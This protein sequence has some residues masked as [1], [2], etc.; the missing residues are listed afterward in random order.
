MEY[1]RIE[2]GFCIRTQ[3]ET[4]P[5][6]MVKL[7][8]QDLTGAI[9][10]QDAG[11]VDDLAAPMHWVKILTDFDETQKNGY[12]LK[13]LA[14][15]IDENHKVDGD[16]GFQIRS[17]R[18]NGVILEHFLRPGR[19]YNPIQHYSYVTNF[20]EPNHRLDEIEILDGVLMHVE[21]GNYANYVN[22]ANGWFEL[23]FSTPIYNWIVDNNF[24]DLHRWLILDR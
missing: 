19:T 18:I 21:S 17:I 11:L 2:L 22:S 5:E 20:L 24:G 9:A 10:L 7:N 15:N 16:F 4:V 13:V 1:L 6:V 8:D 3:I 14:L 23:D 12:L